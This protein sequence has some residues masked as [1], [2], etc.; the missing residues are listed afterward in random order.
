MLMYPFHYRVI[1]SLLSFLF[2]IACPLSP[3]LYSSLTPTLSLSPYLPPSFL[4]LL[5]AYH[6]LSLPL[7]LSLSLR[8]MKEAFMQGEVN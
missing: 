2:F 1:F 6:P 7:S 4:Q 3:S 5:S 8:K